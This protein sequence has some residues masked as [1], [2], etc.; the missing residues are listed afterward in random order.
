ML[1]SN[2][3]GT[4][5]FRKTTKES[6]KCLVKIKERILYKKKPVIRIVLK[7]T[8]SCFN[9]ETYPASF[10]FVYYCRRDHPVYFNFP[11]GHVTHNLP[12]I[13]GARVEFTIREKEVE[14]YCPDN[15]TAHS[16][17]RENKGTVSIKTVGK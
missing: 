13:N 10:F 11:V 15:T 2:D 7:F 14:F 8:Q 6:R 12:L 17:S 9:E 4:N 1:R 3:K 16:N 5:T